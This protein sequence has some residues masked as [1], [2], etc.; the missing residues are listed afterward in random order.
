M[1]YHVYFGLPAGGKYKKNPLTVANIFNCYSD[2]TYMQSVFY[3]VLICEGRGVQYYGT[4][5]L[6]KFTKQRLLC[7]PE[8]A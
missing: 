5:G 2:T 4:T 8:S 1:C 7:L 3:A 6:V